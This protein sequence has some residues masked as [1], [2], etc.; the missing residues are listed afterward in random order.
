MKKFLISIFIIAGIILGLD[1]GVYYKGFYLKERENGSLTVKV[2]TNGQMIEYQNSEGNYEV[3]P[4]KGVDLTSSM[5]GHYMT[6]YA[7]NE[8]TYLRWFKWIQEMGANTIRIPNIMDDAFYQ[9]LYNYNTQNDLPLYI[10]QGISITEYANN[11]REDAYSEAFYQQLKEIGRAA[12]DVIHGKKRIIINKGSGSGHYNKDVSQWVLGYTLATNWNID[13]IAYT[14][15]KGYDTVYKG[16][17]IQTTNEATAFEAMLAKVMDQIIEYESQ[18]YGTQRLLSFMNSPVTDPF[19]YDKHY[20]KQLGK[21]TKLDAENL[22]A[23]T[24]FQSGYFASYAIYEFCENF[25]EYFST[26]QKERLADIQWIEELKGETYD[27]YVSLLNAYHT[28]PVIVGC[29]FSSSRG[30]IT[31]TPLSEFEQGKA[32]VESY[33]DFIKAGSAGIILSVWQDIWGQPTWNTSYAI[34]SNNRHYWHDIQ[35]FNQG[36]GLLSFEPGQSQSTCYIDGRATEWTE[37]DVVIEHEGMKLSMQYN[38]RGVYLLIQGEQL[39]SKQPLYIPIDTTQQTGSNNCEQYGIQFERNA[40]FLLLLDGPNNSRLLVQKRYEAIRANYS[41]ETTG[42]DAYVEVPKADAPL[43]VPIYRVSNDK[44][45]IEQ[46]E[47][48]EEIKTKR[49]MKI[50]ET[51]K[52]HYGNGNPESEKFDSLADFYYG[53]NL[54]EVRIPWQLLNFSDPSHMQIHADYYDHYG[55]E[56][57]AIDKLYIGIAKANAVNSSW[58][59]MKSI[60]LKGW[61]RDIVYHERLK[62]SYYIIKQA[63]GGTW[64]Q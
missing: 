40:D 53:E 17:Y 28:V 56:H 12:V 7:I 8:E 37:E 20:A 54:I 11:N 27:G 5:P 3:L 2:R 21:H 16:K 36:T 4:I 44:D 33:Q 58:I 23:T 6:D 31:H 29:G 51:G 50:V 43:F 59:P 61:G 41:I 18:K 46:D 9:A 14:N 39:N 47:N 42:R 1:Y 38:E 57:M 60:L 48:F 25:W 24:A 19:E 10:L 52:L 30:T 26:G 49:L 13:T 35:S 34:T 63:W 15:H 62:Q 55:V 32:L 64:Q 45:L 22:K